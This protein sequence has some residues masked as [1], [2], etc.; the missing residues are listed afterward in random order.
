MEDDLQYIVRKMTD[1][2]LKAVSEKS[3]LSYM[4]VYRIANGTNTKPSFLTVKKLADYFR[5]NE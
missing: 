1:M 4:T 2:N 5:S 3:G